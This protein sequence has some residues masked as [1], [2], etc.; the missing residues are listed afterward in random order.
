MAESR[1]G[2]AHTAISPHFGSRYAPCDRQLPKYGV[3][4]DRGL[5]QSCFRSTCQARPCYLA[6]G[7]AGLGA[8]PGRARLVWGGRRAQKC[9]FAGEAPGPAVLGRPPQAKVL[10]P[11]HQTAA[12][13]VHGGG[14]I[15]LICPSGGPTGAHTLIYQA[16]PIGRPARKATADFFQ[17]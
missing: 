9:L 6:A 12:Y 2:R 8:Q 11:A 13:H 10:P 4:Q 17:K 1:L 3:R 5:P 14:E 7:Q 16:N 15:S